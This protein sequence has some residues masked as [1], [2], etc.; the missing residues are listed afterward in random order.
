MSIEFSRDLS[1]IWLSLL[2]MITLAPPIVILY[3]AMRGLNWLHQ[4][5]LLAAQKSQQLTQRVSTQVDTQTQRVSQ[6]LIR[7]HQQSARLRTV[8]RKLL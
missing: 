4:R 5:T 6:P 1:L 7:L 8:V 3:F 2:C